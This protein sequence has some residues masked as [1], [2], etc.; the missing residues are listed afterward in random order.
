MG[1]QNFRNSPSA[2]QI[3]RKGE[4]WREGNWDDFTRNTARG[5][6]MQKY[7]S[8]KSDAN[9]NGLGD[10]RRKV[11]L[12]NS[13]SATGQAALKALGDRG[14]PGQTISGT[15]CFKKESRGWKF[16]LLPDNSNK[17]TTPTPLRSR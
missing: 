16:P 13:L 8:G 12:D 2:G 7:N 14:H 9:K 1:V 11:G 5:R 17:G 10:T 4:L 6:V 3:K 15:T